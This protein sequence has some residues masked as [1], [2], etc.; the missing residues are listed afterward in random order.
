MLSDHCA[1]ESL[2]RGNLPV[3]VDSAPP[4]YEL[5]QRRLAGLEKLMQ[6]WRSARVAEQPVG[7]PHLVLDDHRSVAEEDGAVDLLQGGRGYRRTAAGVDA[8]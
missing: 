7:A 4:L 1:L 5:K 6:S 8:G 3:L 2:Y